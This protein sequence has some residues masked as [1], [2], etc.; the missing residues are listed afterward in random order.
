MRTS[1]LHHVTAIAACAVRSHRFYASTLGLPLVKRTVTHD[2]P[3][4][5]HLY[6]GD[7]AGRPGT[8][9]SLFV[10]ERAA[11]GRPGKGE[12]ERL[13]LRAPAASLD[14]WHG[15]LRLAAVQLEGTATFLDRPAL[16]FRDPSGVPLALLGESGIAAEP[17][18]ETD[19]VPGRHALRGLFGVILTVQDAASLA[20]ILSDV[21]GLREAG[22]ENGCV[23]LLSGADVGGSILLHQMPGSARGRLGRGTINHVAFRAADPAAQDA[24]VERL[25]SAHGIVATPPID[26]VYY[27]SVHFRE[28]GGFMFEIATDGP[29]FAVDEPLESLGERLSL[30]PFLEGKRAAIE[31]G[32]EPIG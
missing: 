21:L 29:G 32:L 15:R 24:M 26:R 17:A 28:P 19:K 1:G 18:W 3:G 27:R 16:Y 4:A 13:F 12:A 2:D 5:Y 7:A 9:F 10:W 14:W 30:P 31:A 11:A 23:R 8:I 6:Y 25:R 22:R 20:A